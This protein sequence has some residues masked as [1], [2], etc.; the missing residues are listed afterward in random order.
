MYSTVAIHR[1]SQEMAR[2]IK[3]TGQLRLYHTSWLHAP[4]STRLGS[5]LEELSAV[6]PGLRR[7]LENRRLQIPE[8]LPMKLRPSE[9]FLRLMM[10]SGLGWKRAG[11]VIWE[12]QQKN[13]ALAAARLLGTGAFSAYLGLEYGALEALQAAKANGVRTCLVFTSPHYSFWEEW[14]KRGGC[15]EE[16]LYPSRWW[17]DRFRRCYERIDEEIKLASLIRTNSALVG[18]SLQAAGVPQEKIVDVPLGADIQETQPMVPR[19]QQSIVK[20]IVSGQVSL[21]KG[22][23]LLLE[24]WRQL[25]PAH[26]ELHF[27]GGN[28]LPDKFLRGIPAS[29]T[30]HGNRKRSEVRRAYQESDVLILPTLCDGFGMVIPEAMA[31]GCAVI[32]TTNAGAVDWIEPGQNGWVVEAANV[33]A[34]KGGIQ[35]ALGAGHQRLDEMRAHAQKTARHRTWQNFRQRFCKCL[36]EEKFFAA[37][38]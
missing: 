15:G 35:Q 16:D 38:A 28:L 11:H 8:P 7:S 4:Q 5:V 33:E 36:Y 1:H 22:A 2:A 13:L 6:V 31:A 24:A 26:A 18:R 10:E 37:Q 34:L 30:F 32:T 29:V 12:R 21:R 25:H 20:F 14:A 23:H 19:P 27:F 3:E 9:E 17:R